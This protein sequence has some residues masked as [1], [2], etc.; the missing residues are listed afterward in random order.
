MKTKRPAQANDLRPE[1]NFDYSTAVRGKYYRRLIRE[2]ANVAVLEP[3][4]AEV[5]RT[6]AAVN[7]ALRSLLRVS[8]NTRR[9][10]RPANRRGASL[11]R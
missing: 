1:Y 11:P 4:V 8:A 9:R 7:E 5:F 6:S 2:G 3:D 10:T